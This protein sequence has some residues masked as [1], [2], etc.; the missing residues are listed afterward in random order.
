[1]LSEIARYKILQMICLVKKEDK[2][3]PKKHAVCPLVVRC[4]C[5]PE[6][7]SPICAL[8]AYSSSYPRA[9]K[10]RLA[11]SSRTKFATPGSVSVRVSD[12]S[13]D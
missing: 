7:F 11:S 3:P 2:L 4:V 8:H 12:R 5:G 6:E 1:M 10:T 9:L 13:W